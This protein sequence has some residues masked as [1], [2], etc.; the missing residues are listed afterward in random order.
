MTARA[1]DSRP[2]PSAP[3]GA[4]KRCSVFPLCNEGTK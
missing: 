2:G 1:E 4:A 3:A